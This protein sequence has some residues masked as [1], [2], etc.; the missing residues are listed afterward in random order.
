MSS[1]EVLRIAANESFKASDISAFMPRGLQFPEMPVQKFSCS[2]AGV[3]PDAPGSVTG[4]TTSENVEPPV[5]D[6]RAADT[7]TKTPSDSNA[8][9]VDPFV[10]LPCDMTP[11]LKSLNQSN[12]NQPEMTSAMRLLKFWC[13]ISCNEHD[14]HHKLTCFKQQ[15]DHRGNPKPKGTCRFNFP[16]PMAGSTTC[17][18]LEI[19][20][21]IFHDRPQP[22]A[23]SS[24]SNVD[25]IIKRLLGHEYINNFVPPVMLGLRSNNDIRFLMFDAAVQFYVCKYVVRQFMIRLIRNKYLFWVFA[26]ICNEVSNL[27]R[28]CTRQDSCSPRSRKSPNIRTIPG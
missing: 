22:A 6:R 16:R 19:L 10:S 9:R 26:Q 27:G 28:A 3:D 12:S 17:K 13:T 1:H 15:L 8:K 4:A 24:T 23:S 21:A 2:S 18:R 7:G 11:I 14:Y 20:R 25:V 5:T